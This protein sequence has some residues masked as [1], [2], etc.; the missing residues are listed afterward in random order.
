MISKASKTI[1]VLRRLKSLGV[2]QATIV[3]YWKSEG[4]VHLEMACPVWHSGLTVAQSKS[5]ERVQ[6]VAMAA[7]TAWGSSYSQQ[8]LDL[9][10]ERLSVRRE[11]LC[12]HFAHKT[13]KKSRHTYLFEPVINT[14]N[15]RNQKQK[16]MEP[17]ARTT[18]YYK[19]PIQYLTRLLNNE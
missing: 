11:M 8:L 18:S 15:M 10:L 7:I 14:F 2:D 9:N 16:Y 6:K 4:R 12:K 1:W 19:S 3:E 5:L 13:A 17:R